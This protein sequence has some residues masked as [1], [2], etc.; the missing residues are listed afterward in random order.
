MRLKIIF[1]AGKIFNA[2]KFSDYETGYYHIQAK[3]QIFFG[4]HG[5]FV[6]S[7]DWRRKILLVR[8]SFNR[9]GFKFFLVY[10]ISGTVRSGSKEKFCAGKKN[11]V[12]WLIA[13]ACNGIYS[14]GSSGENF[15]RTFFVNVGLLYNFLCCFALFFN[16][17]WKEA[18]LI[19][20]EELFLCSL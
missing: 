19:F 6:N 9:R 3:L 8:F 4:S 14:F 7:A 12:D 5:N 15:D 1:V 10:F 11:Y 2:S 20:V 17:F 18:I 13:P 16:L